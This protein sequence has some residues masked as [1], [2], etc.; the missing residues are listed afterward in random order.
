M[1]LGGVL[2]F[3]LTL[4]WVRTRELREKYAVVWL[5]VAC[6]LLLCGLFPHALEALAQ[7]AHLSYPS[8]VL[9]L[10]LAAIYVFSFS[11]SVSL[12]RLHR[13]NTRLLQELSLLEQRI[14]ELEERHVESA[15]RI[16]NEDRPERSGAGAAGR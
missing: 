7:W 1:L 10:S 12:T 11:V 6:L 5:G 4:V 13:C 15:A 8:A 3:V 2:A 14:R 16:V 9:F